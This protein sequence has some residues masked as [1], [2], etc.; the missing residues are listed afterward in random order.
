M[1]AQFTSWR[2]QS[3]DC[4][5]FDNLGPVF[6]SAMMSESGGKE[7]IQLEFL[8]Q[9]ASEPAGT[10]L[11]WLADRERAE[12]NLADVRSVGR[13]SVPVGEKT[14][15]LALAIFFEDF[16][17][18][19][20]L[21]KLRGV[22]FTEI[23]HTALQ[24]TPFGESNALSQG[25]IDVLLTVFVPD[26]SLEE[27][28]SRMTRRQKSWKGVGRHTDTFAIIGSQTHWKSGTRLRKNRI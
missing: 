10:V 21:L 25:I 23:E 1:D 18:T 19:L 9:T 17:G 2:A 5:E 28:A 4:E 15:L 26:V 6:G 13:V 3:V 24:D 22:E 11:P 27:H 7:V 14:E 12:A 16:D 8:K 20:P